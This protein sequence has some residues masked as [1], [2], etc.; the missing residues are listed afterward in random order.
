MT[1]RSD[2]II[3]LIALH[4]ALSVLRPGKSQGLLGC[5]YPAYVCWVIFSVLLPGLAFVN[6]VK[7]QA[8]ISQGTYCF[9]PVR[10]IWYRL[11]L[12]W[13]PRYLILCTI[14]IIYLTIYIYT[15]MQFGKFNIN[16]TSSKVSTAPGASEGTHDR[17]A[18]SSRI[19]RSNCWFKSSEPESSTILEEGPALNDNENSARAISGSSEQAPSTPSPARMFRKPT[20]LEALRD[21][22]LLPF[23]NNGLPED[24]NPTL[25]KR[26]KAIKRQLR[27]MFIYPLVYL[28]MWIAPFINH[29]YFYTKEHNPPFILNC[30]SLVSLCL[31]CAMDCLIFSIRERPWRHSIRGQTA[32]RSRQSS[33]G[34]SSPI[35][36]VD[37]AGTSRG[38]ENPDLTPE[39]PAMRFSRERAG[40]Q[41][42]EKNWWDNEAM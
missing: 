35:G 9:L 39:T 16:I 30:I 40:R 41:P 36:M 27:Y 2:F 20:L 29:C 37:F 6:P 5:R 19:S 33:A 8:Y 3:L 4:T 7:G 15:M 38:T 18:K 11:A 17:P 21:R 28:L 10:P 31:Q 23:G 26:H 1:E 14:A 34:G 12:S 32:S 25:R 22:S 13:I 24:A 42:P